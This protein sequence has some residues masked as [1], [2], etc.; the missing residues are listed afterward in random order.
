LWTLADRTLLVPRRRQR[1]QQQQQQWR[2][3]VIAAVASERRATTHGWR[4]SEMHRPTVSNANRPIYHYVGR[5]DA[6]ERP[7]LSCDLR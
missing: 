4:E 1:Q 6:A 7:V 2:V 5:T 3:G